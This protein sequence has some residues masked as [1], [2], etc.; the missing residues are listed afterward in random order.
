[1]GVMVA[2]A[3]G[4]PVVCVHPA[5]VV[6]SDDTG[7]FACEAFKKEKGGGDVFRLCSAAE[8]GAKHSVYTKDA[9]VFGNGLAVKF[10]CTIS[11][12]GT[13]APLV[14]VVNGL[15]ANELSPEKCPSGMLVMKVEGFCVGGGRHLCHDA[16][17]R[18][19]LSR[20]GP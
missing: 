11:G 17:L 9:P 4:V 3:L 8:K 18:G 19:V 6:N 1:M 16:G 7:L 15:T 2:E 13:L 12:V 14:A 5:C 20:E 10:T